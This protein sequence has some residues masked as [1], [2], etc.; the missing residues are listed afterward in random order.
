MHLLK[1]QLCIVRHFAF[2]CFSCR[3]ARVIRL[4]EYKKSAKDLDRAAMDYPH[5]TK[6]RLWKNKNLWHIVGFWKG[7]SL[8][9][10]VR[11]KQRHTSRS[12]LYLIEGPGL[13]I[14][15]RSDLCPLCTL[16]VEAFAIS[17]LLALQH[18][19]LSILN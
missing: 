11:S 1:Q 17:R 3:R 12:Y 4:G 7:L 18:T 15:R 16:N 19:K 8:N 10:L 5:L 2:L 13:C 9:Y 14:P 6:D